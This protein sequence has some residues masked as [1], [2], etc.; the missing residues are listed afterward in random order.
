MQDLVSQSDGG[1][2]VGFRWAT[3]GALP[4][5]VLQFEHV[6]PEVDKCLTDPHYQVSQGPSPKGS[7]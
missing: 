7:S 6:V 4:T 3:W 5:S 2:D 1:G